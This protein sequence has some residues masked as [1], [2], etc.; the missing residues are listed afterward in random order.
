M[1]PV[2]LRELLL[3]MTMEAAAAAAGVLTLTPQPRPLLLD[4]RPHPQ[5]QLEQP[6]AAPTAAQVVPSASHPGP[7]DRLASVWLV[8]V[9][10]HQAHDPLLQQLWLQEVVLPPCSRAA[11]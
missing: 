6:V 10:L 3:E 1:P 11:P 9:Q 8:G 2:L 4:V 5:R 7:L